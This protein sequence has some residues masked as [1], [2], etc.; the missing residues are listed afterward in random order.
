VFLTA[1][2]AGAQVT[3]ATVSGLVTDTTAAVLPGATVTLTNDD[4]AGTTTGVT[5]ER[6]EFTLPFVPVGR[7]TLTVALS[8]FTDYAQRDLALSAAQSVRLTVALSVSGQ[9]ETVTVAGGATLINRANGQQQAIVRDQQLREPPLAKRSWAQTVEPDTSAVQNG[10]DWPR[11]DKGYA[12]WSP[13][14]IATSA[15]S[16]IR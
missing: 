7:Y 10:T 5:N 1:T 12:A 14:S 13:A 3:T 16:S 11:P 6:G 9:T 15:A 8:G 2:L 4:T